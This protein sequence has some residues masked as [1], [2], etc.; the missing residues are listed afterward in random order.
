M[1]KDLRAE[2]MDSSL[3]HFACDEKVRGSAAGSRG[4]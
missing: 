4:K 3:G 2:W 1:E